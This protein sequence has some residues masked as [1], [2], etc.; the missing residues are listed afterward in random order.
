MLF[1]K[2]YTGLNRRISK[3]SPILIVLAW[4]GVAGIAYAT[5]CP[6]GLRPHFANADEERFGA[7]FVLGIILAFAAPRHWIAT[8]AFVV[9]LAM[10]LEA[11]QLLVPGRDAVLHDAF[12]KAV[13]GV[14]GSA[15][16]H[17]VFAIRRALVRMT[18]R[19]R[20]AKASVSQLPIV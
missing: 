10:G 12:V 8:A 11:A 19:G 13:G 16:G 20:G 18:G 15:L 14:L 2:R 4:L 9:V 1:A 5:L 7:Y 17:S 6:I 3:P